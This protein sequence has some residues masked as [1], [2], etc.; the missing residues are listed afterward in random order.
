M[1]ALSLLAITLEPPAAAADVRLGTFGRVQASSDLTGGEGNAVN[2]V[3]FQS[4]LEKSP[5]MELDVAFTQPDDQGGAFMAVTTVALAGDLFHYTGEWDADLAV[6]NLY[7]AY[8]DS[9]ESA[10]W[11][12]WAGSRMARG[13][14]LYLMDFWPLDDLNI[15]GGGGQL[16][17][18]HLSWRLHGGF[19]RLEGGD[20][21]SQ[22][23]PLPEAGG[24][25]TEEVRVLDRQRMVAASRLEWRP[26]EQRFFPAFRVYGEVH[27]LPEGTRLV[28]EGLLEET[29][30]AD[31][32]LL[33]GGQVLTSAEGE[34]ATLRTTAWY[35]VAT[36]LAAYDELAI[37]TD[38]FAA[39]DTVAAASQHRVAL[40]SSAHFRRAAVQFG[41]YVQRF[42]DADAAADD[43]DDHW[44]GHV[45]IRPQL[46]VTDKVNLGVELS[47]QWL[48]PDGL[49]P[50][51]DQW[52]VP[53]VTKLAILPALQPAPGVWA[54][55]QIRLQY[56]ATVL[57]DDARLWFAWQ[58]ER[59]RYNLQ[60]FVGV[61]AEWWINSVNYDR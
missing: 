46:F 23:V 44:E 29:L 36:G 52:D 50:R 28:E 12:A 15:V 21:Q 31:R 20:Y 16:D 45:A 43:V 61:G 30:P 26:N 42:E 54:R 35:R 27:R 60:H 47:H 49:N 40:Q 48:V 6:R 38:G 13:D 25:G 1:I 34:D 32:G 17:T 8:L 39:D 18:A 4:R 51:T 41:G 9:N 11:S 19:N 14:D 24:V 5:Y 37:P 57:N 56:I 33:L 59:A 53:Q 55:P 10:G 22:V 7:A 3:D 58:D 2:V